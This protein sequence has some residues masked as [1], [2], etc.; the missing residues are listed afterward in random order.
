[1][2]LLLAAGLSS[3]LCGWF[4]DRAQACVRVVCLPDVAASGRRC[5]ERELF[6]SDLTLIKSRAPGSLS[7][8]KLTTVLEGRLQTGGFRQV[9]AHRS[10]REI[11]SDI[12]K[13]RS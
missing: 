11:V 13:D 5:R 8:K 10:V 3:T 1:M 6:L 4:I 9:N 2:G 12:L 7:L